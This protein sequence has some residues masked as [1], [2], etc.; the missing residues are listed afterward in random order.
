MPPVWLDLKRA[1]IFIFLALCCRLETQALAADWPQFLGPTRDAV[2]AGSDLA[3]T[4][5]ADGPPV[6]WRKNIGQGFS[7]IAVANHLLILFHRLA[8]KETV[9]CLDARTGAPKWS[10]SYPTSYRD[11]FGFD[12]G[13]RATPCIA[14]GK[15][16]TFGA[17][18]MLLCLDMIDGK[19][20]WQLDTK[21]EFHQ[22][23][24]FFGEACSPLVE[25]NTVLLNIGGT[26]G[27]GI[28]AFDSGSGRVV[29]KGTD[30][31]AGYSSPIAATIHGRRYA[32]FFT[33]AGLV[34][35]DPSD[36]AVQFQFPWRSR[37]NA[38]VNAATPVIM[39]DMVFI[40][41]C[42]GTGAILLRV[43]DHA[44]EKIWSGD[45]ILSTHYATSV[46]RGDFLYGINGRADPGFSPAPTLRCVEFKT[47]KIRWQEDSVGASSLILCNDRLLI[48]TDKGELIN[49]AAAPDG[50]KEF[51]RAQI[52]PDEVR[53]FPALADGFLYARGKDKLFCFDLSRKHEK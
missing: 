48:L 17:E 42:Y 5:P 25:G 15:V 53:A 39:D 34:A 30:D 47:G 22:G 23:K 18:G 33:R 35:A 52:M 28:V 32:F 9:E 20:I 1:S 10:Y 4:W 31:E 43:R 11:D 21:K 40:S 16:Y 49:A 12:E 14:N 7:G 37:D 8:D 3:A 13:P 2:Y 19:K 26:D 27:A 50:Y 6:V 44:V 41:A 51:A 45:D 24:G 29:W 46:R 38:S 36:G